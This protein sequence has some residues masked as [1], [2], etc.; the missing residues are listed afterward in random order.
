MDRTRDFVIKHFEL[1]IVGV[2]VA[3]TA[4]AILVAANKL[5]F[6]NFFYIPVLV[7]AYFL[8]KRQGVFVAL[9][10]VLMVG[11][12]AV[13]NPGIFEPA[14]LDSPLLNIGLWAGFTVVTAYVVGTLY[15]VKAEA[16]TDLQKAYS[17]VLE[18]L[19]KYIDAVDQYTNNHS[20]RVSEMGVRIGQVMGLADP[21]LETVRVGGLLHDIGKIDISL[22]VLRKASALDPEEWKQMKTHAKAGG[23]LLSPVGGLLSSVVPLVEFH[24]EN[25]DGTGYSGLAGDD[26]PLGARIL[27]V[28]DAYDSMITDRPYRAGRT[29]S[30]AFAEVDRCSGKQFDPTVVHAFRQVM[31]REFERV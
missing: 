20:V 13:I 3:A 14:R 8:G 2:L 23:R 16:V 5:A 29:P 7:A 25:F 18:I 10:A 26:I 12:Y 19:S 27:A 4:F 28:A 24:H 6:L 31:L 30:D 15:D 1:V 17:G 21:E 9:A 11:T 22:D